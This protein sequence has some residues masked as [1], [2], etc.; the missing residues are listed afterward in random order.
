LWG[1]IFQLLILVAESLVFCSGS[2]L[3]YQ[4]IQ[5]YFPVSLL[6]DLEYL[7]LCYGLWFTWTWINLHSSTYRH[8]VQPAPFVEDAL[9][10][11]L[12][13]FGLFVKNQVSIGVWLYSR[14]FFFILLKNLPVLIS[15]SCSFN[16]YFFVVQLE[17]RDGDI[18]RSSF[19][20]QNCLSHPVFF[21][22]SIWS[23]ELFS[24]VL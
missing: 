18:F 22:F 2:C 13:S 16:H 5:G 9:P 20:V 7:I 6:L 3:L 19:I 23:W 15:I 21:F 14:V 11:P 12:Y 1:P 8:P 17:V 10:F 4:R 24:Q